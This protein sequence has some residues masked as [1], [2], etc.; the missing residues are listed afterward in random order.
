[1]T[2]TRDLDASAGSLLSCLSSIFCPRPRRHE[3]DETRGSYQGA[4]RDIVES[5]STLRNLQSMQSMQ[6]T[7]SSPSE[8]VTMPQSPVVRDKSPRSPRRHPRSHP[9]S[10][11]ALTTTRENKY[12]IQVRLG[13]EVSER[14]LIMR[15]VHYF[16]GRGVIHSCCAN[17]ARDNLLPSL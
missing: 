14:L 6:S 8:I 10:F 2:R 7:P 17:A 11:G 15:L 16:A 12:V 13:P 9:R 3:A 5:R 1:M 4:R